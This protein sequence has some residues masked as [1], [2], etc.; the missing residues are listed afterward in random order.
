MANSIM[1]NKKTK[2]FSRFI[3]NE[4]WHFPGKHQGTKLKDL[5][6]HYLKWAFNTYRV[7]GPQSTMI[8]MELSRRLG[9]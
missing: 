4:I 5:P 8:Q 1:A 9:I 7:N 6:M 3:E 2:Q